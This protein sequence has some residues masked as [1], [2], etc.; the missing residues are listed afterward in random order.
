MTKYEVEITAAT[1]NVEADSEEEAIQEALDCHELD[2]VNVIE[3][4]AFEEDEDD[5]EDE[6]E[7]ERE[8]DEE[9]EEEE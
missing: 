2:G 7:L 4:E 1:Y 3:V 5:D 8:E 9:E 6:N